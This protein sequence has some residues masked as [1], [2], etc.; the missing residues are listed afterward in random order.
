M[1]FFTGKGLNVIRTS[2]IIQETGIRTAKVGQT[3]I[4]PCFCQRNTVTYLYWYHQSLGG[5]PHVIS[6]RMKHTPEAEISS[7]YKERFRALAGSESTVNDLT[8]KDLLPADSGTYYCVVLEFNAIEFGPGVF[9][10]VQSSSSN[11]PPPIHQP[12]VKLLQ[13]GE[14]GN[15]SCSVSAEPCEGE[16]SLY[17]FR[18]TASQPALMYPGIGQCKRLSNGTLYGINCTSNLQLDPVTS[19]DAGTYHC[20]LVSCGVVVFGEGT[21]VEITGMRSLPMYNSNKNVSMI[22]IIYN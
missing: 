12:A 8:I 6:K 10:H 3:V 13:L 14:S 2:D 16:H 18:R 22:I 1:D 21:K 9:L 15:L 7:L 17:W 19:S 11:F 20:A 5:K 4:L